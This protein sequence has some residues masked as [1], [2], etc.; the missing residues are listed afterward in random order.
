MELE[1][2]LLLGVLVISVLLVLPV[3]LALWKFRNASSEADELIQE[4]QK[5]TM[6]ISAAVI[7]AHQRSSGFL[8]IA[9]AYLTVALLLLTIILAILTFKSVW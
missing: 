4:W 5:G 3:L 2:F 8:Q 7:V 9:L 1:K 6:E